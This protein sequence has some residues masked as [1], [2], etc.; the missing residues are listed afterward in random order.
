M[1]RITPCYQKELSPISIER[2][3]PA[4]H[5]KINIRISEEIN[6]REVQSE[7]AVWIFLWDLSSGGFLQK[8]E[9]L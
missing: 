8:K 5:L 3:L 9:D 4:L 2:G 6:T 7:A 1:K